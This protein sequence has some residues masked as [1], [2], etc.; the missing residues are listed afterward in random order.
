MFSQLGHLQFT[1]LRSLIA[2]DRQ[3]I[4]GVFVN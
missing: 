1:I 4:K 2:V 3:V